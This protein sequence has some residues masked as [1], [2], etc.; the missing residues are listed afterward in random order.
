MIIYLIG[1]PADLTKMAIQNLTPPDVWLMTDI[2]D[3]TR[4]AA[5]WERGSEYAINMNPKKREYR[6]FMK[7]PYGWIYLF[8]EGS[9]K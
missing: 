2:R 5:R 3:D 9:D 4:S 7:T 1:G 6:K 8:V